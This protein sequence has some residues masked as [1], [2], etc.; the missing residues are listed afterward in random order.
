LQAVPCIVKENC[1][2]GVF[3]VIVHAL[4]VL[5]SHDGLSFFFCLYIISIDL[6]I[7]RFFLVVVVFLI[8]GRLIVVGNMCNMGTTTSLYRERQAETDG[9]P[10]SFFLLSFYFYFFIFL[11]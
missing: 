5:Q 8:L 10:D 4:H 3:A 7:I 2:G 1:G 6:F 9:V 11:D